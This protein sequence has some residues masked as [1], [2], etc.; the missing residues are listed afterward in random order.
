MPLILRRHRLCFLFVTVAVALLP[1]SR[2]LAA[3]PR[4]E[5]DDRVLRAGV[6]FRE[7]R[8]MP[9]KR[10]PAELFARSRCVA[11]IPNVLKA[12]WFFGGRYGK[13]VLSCRSKTGEWSPPVIVMMTGGSFGLQFGASSTDVVLFFMTTGSVRSL[14]SNKV[15]LSGDAGIAAGPVGRETEAATDAQ[16]T[17]EIYSYAR[18]RGLFA[19]IS[20]AGSYI[21]V[22]RE[23]TDAYYG[24]A[25]SPTGILFDH[26]VTSVPKS[27]WSFLNAL[28][29]SR[30]A[31]AAPPKPATEPVAAPPPK[32]ERIPAPEKPRPVPQAEARPEPRPVPRVEPRPAARPAP[33][34]ADGVGEPRTD[35]LIP[36]RP[37]APQGPAN[38]QLAP[39]VPPSK[40]KAT[41]TAPL[42]PPASATA[43]KPA[44][45]VAKPVSPAVKPA[46]AAAKPLKPP[47]A[48]P[49]VH[50]EPQFEGP[51]L[52]PVDVPPTLPP[53]RLMP[54]P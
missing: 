11:V 18:S 36:L 12:A 54:P 3:T 5:L 45:P 27:A 46:A 38:R 40:A 14:L 28:P 10:I 35:E 33:P 39:I 23:D 21:G 26:K 34:V 52:P 7:L 48:A 49:P 22:H 1:V 42:K 13:G 4:D 9:D 30:V 25:Y 15:K 31:A 20:L 41:T 16:F 29:R 50:H 6:A 44:A 32:L 43:V 2:S 37:P 19:G 17:A 8:E 47:P 53:V 24:Q 51:P